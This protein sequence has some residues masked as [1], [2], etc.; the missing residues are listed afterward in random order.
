MTDHTTV[1][2][3]CW[4]IQEALALYFRLY[5]VWPDILCAPPEIIYEARALLLQPQDSSI[6]GLRQEFR[7]VI[8][9]VDLDTE[10]ATLEWYVTSTANTKARVWGYRHDPSSSV[11]TIGRTDSDSRGDTSEE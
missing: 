5:G 7:K 9:R 1:H 2:I 4:S 10:I 3:S 6:E 11:R 8:K